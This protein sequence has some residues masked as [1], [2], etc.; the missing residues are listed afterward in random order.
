M[1]PYENK[2]KHIKNSGLLSE[3]QYQD[4]KNF[5]YGTLPETFVDYSGSD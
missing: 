3:C 4:L 1:F 5:T 2:N